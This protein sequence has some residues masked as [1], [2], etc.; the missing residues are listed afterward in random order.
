MQTKKIIQEV[1]SNYKNKR[2]IPT[3]SDGGC[4]RY[5]MCNTSA[6]ETWAS[7]TLDGDIKNILPIIELST[8]Q[9]N[10]NRKT[11]LDHTATYYKLRI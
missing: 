3:G 4:L 6:G 1:L 8:T 11:L 5:I 7:I 9:K 10:G 2:Y